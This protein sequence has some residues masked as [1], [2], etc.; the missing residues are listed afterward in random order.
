MQRKTAKYAHHCLGSV[1]HNLMEAGEGVGPHCV[2]SRPSLSPGHP[3]HKVLFL[4]LR[5]FRLLLIS[6][7]L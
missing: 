4:L 6:G 2:G 1:V 7:G 3:L 5:V